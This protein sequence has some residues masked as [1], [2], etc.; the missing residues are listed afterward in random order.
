[1]GLRDH[2]EES[3]PFAFFVTLQDQKIFNALAEAEGMRIG[4]EELDDTAILATS[5]SMRER[6]GEIE[7]LLRSS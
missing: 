2:D 3:I 1:M 5:S 7:R 4:E 6:S